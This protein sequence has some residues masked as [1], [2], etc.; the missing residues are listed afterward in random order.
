MKSVRIYSLRTDDGVRYMSLGN[1]RWVRSVRNADKTW[2]NT[3]VNDRD[4]PDHVK[5]KFA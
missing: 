5:A 2:T 1:G 3:I 4:V